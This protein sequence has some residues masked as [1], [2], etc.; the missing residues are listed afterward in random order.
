MYAQKKKNNKYNFELDEI[1]EFLFKIIYEINIPFI[2][3][4]RRFFVPLDACLFESKSNGLGCSIP[5]MKSVYFEIEKLLFKKF[6]TSRL[7]KKI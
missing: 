5:I 3:I 2:I 1:F 4:K 6:C 7:P